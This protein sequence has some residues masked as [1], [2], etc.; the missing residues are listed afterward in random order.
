MFSDLNKLP[1]LLAALARSTAGNIIP[2]TAAAI[3]L[4]AGMVG[5]GIDISRS[6][7]VENRLQNACDAGTLAGRRAVDTHGFDQT[8][9]DQA[10]LFF[11]TNFDKDKEGA[12]AGTFTPTSSDNGNTVSAT[13][14]ATLPTVVM[15]LF[16]YDETHLQVTCSAS[17]SV[18]NSDVVMVLDTTGSMATSLGY[19]QPTR[20]GALQSAMKNFYTTVKTATA[21]SN[22]RVRYGFVPFSSSVN[23]GHLLYD[24]DPDYITDSHLYQT[25]DPHY[26]QTTVQDFDHWSDPVHTTGSGTGNVSYDD[27]ETLTSDYY[28]SQN[29]CNN[30]LPA[31]TAWSNYGSVDTSDATVTINGQGQQVTSTTT[32]QPQRSIDYFCSKV[33]TGNWWNQVTRYYVAYR[34][35]YRDKY[36]YGYDTR[37]AV[38][39]TVTKDVFANYFDYH[40]AARD[41]STFK[42]FTPV[43]FNI[44]ETDDWSGNITGLAA[45][46]STWNGCIEE[47]KTVADD[48]FSWSALTGLSPSDALDLDIDAAPDASDDDTKWAPQWPEMEYLR[49]V[50][51]TSHGYTNYTVK[52]VDSSIYGKKANSYCPHAAQLLQT[53]DQDDFN[54][55]ADQLYASGSTYLDLGLLWGGRLSSP[56]GIFSSNVNDEPQNGGKVARHIIFMTDGFMEPDLEVY[57]GYG[58]EIHDKRITGDGKSNQ[59]SRHSARFRMVCDQIKS[60]GIRIW[61]IAFTSALSSDLENCAST[62]SSFTA[63][64]SDQLNSAFQEIA[65]NVGELR[66]VS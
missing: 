51:T 47:R 13:A 38:N 34:Y 42:T 10:N 3:F 55:F 28:N 57:S 9:L 50:K 17:M 52:D 2:M 14:T 63:S 18:G 66:V 58:V 32:T 49:T 44:G 22:A 61:V 26:D 45:V 60:K 20:L 27:N 30:H 16:G 15:N 11:Y 29:S 37:T 5:G 19:H 46:T 12:S 54:D 64:N 23:V 53:M 33:T 24:L 48:T 4:L 41:T 36:S 62:N 56:S 31:D 65:K 43:S 21:G 1:A 39:V 6:Y 40:Q 7:M 35:Q 25:R 8:A 59:A